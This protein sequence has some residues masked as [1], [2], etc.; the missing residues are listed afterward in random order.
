MAGNSTNINKFDGFI[1]I[2]IAVIWFFLL[3]VA[4]ALALKA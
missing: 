4:S 1:V 3:Y 2:S